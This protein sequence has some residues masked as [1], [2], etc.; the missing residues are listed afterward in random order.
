MEEKENVAYCF[1]SAYRWAKMYYD[2]KR[3]AI[4]ENLANFQK[5]TIY[6]IYFSNLIS[7]L[8]DMEKSTLDQVMEGVDQVLK[9][10]I[11]AEM[12]EICRYIKVAYSRMIEEEKVL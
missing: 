10:N 5:N 6:K 8:K 2:F 9:R 12:V 1:A 7:R 4:K 3:K 11:D